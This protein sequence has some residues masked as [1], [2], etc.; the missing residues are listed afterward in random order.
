MKKKYA[1]NSEKTYYYLRWFCMTALLLA[2]LSG[3]G[4]KV[5]GQEITAKIIVTADD[6][7]IQ[8]Q[9]EFNTNLSSTTATLTFSN[10]PANKEINTVKVNGNEVKANPD[11]KNTYTFDMTTP[12]IYYVTVTT[13]EKDGA[14]YSITTNVTG[15][16]KSLLE[17]LGESDT[18]AK[19]ASVTIDPQQTEESKKAG[20]IEIINITA[21]ATDGSWTAIPAKDDA[22]SLTFEMPAANVIVTIRTKSATIAKEEAPKEDAPEVTVPEI[23]IPKESLPEEESDRSKLQL[24]VAPAPEE[25]NISIHD[26]VEALILS[27]QIPASFAKNLVVSDIKLINTDDS[28]N[29]VQPT[30]PVTITLPYPKGADN[31]KVFRILHLHD[32]GNYCIITPRAVKAGL[33]FEADHFSLFGIL[34]ASTVSATGVSISPDSKTLNKGETVQLT[35]TVLPTDATDKTVIW[36]SSNNDIASVND[37][38]EVTAVGPG[39]ATIT[40]TANDGSG[41]AASCRITVNEPYTPPAIVHV[42]GISLDRETATIQKGSILQLSA[43]VTP[44]NADDKTV[45]WESSNTDVATVD[46]N[47]KVTAIAP[48]TATITVTTTDQRKTATCSVTVTDI[49]TGIDKIDYDL[50]IYTSA[51]SIC[52]DSPRPVDISV[53]SG[54]GSLLHRFTKQTACRIPASPGFYLVRVDNK[55]YKII[56]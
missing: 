2:G 56:L 35:A 45:R 54:T 40:A 1:T 50:R 39:T 55:T 4:N 10:L 15:V 53:F 34:Y 9:V 47:G 21:H 13:K 5:C 22:S 51:G 25:E 11:D 3:I 33:Q 30:G 32:A 42:T 26:K 24:S 23:A 20:T 52:I 44:S 31:S 41:K 37:N 36:S 46:D 8:H 28:N 49:A 16:D 18:T 7:A 29:E 38:G 48:G 17:N 19:G 43:T 27:D 12:D 6:P 14:T